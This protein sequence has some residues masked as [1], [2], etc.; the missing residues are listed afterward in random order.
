MQHLDDGTLQ[1]LLD[2][3]RSGLS[4]AERAAAEEHL[5]SCELCAR[6]LSELDAL[7]ER[8][9]TLLSEPASADVTVPPYENVVARADRD[10]STD[11][12]RRGR[13]EERVR[14]LAYRMRKR[15][16]AAA[17]AASVVL[18]VGIGWLANGQHRSSDAETE[19]AVADEVGADTLVVSSSVA[20]VEAGTD[21]TGRSDTLATF[22]RG[23]VTDDS[24][25]PLAGAQVSV[26]GTGV[27]ALTNRD[28]AFE[29]SVKPNADDSITRDVTL[30]AQMIGYAEASQTL[31]ARG[32]RVVSTDFR[33]T[34]Q[35]VALEGMVVSAVGDTT[36]SQGRSLG[37]RMDAPVVDSS[38]FPWR[39]VSAAVAQD[40]A[41]FRP[42]T[43]PG[44]R[45]LRI[46]VG[47]DEATPLVRILQELDDGGRLELVEAS[48]SQS[49]DRY[50]ASD[51]RSR[52]SVR[53]GDVWVAATAPLS[54]DSLTALLGRL[55]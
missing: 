5:A 54:R 11:R 16:R 49:P 14:G 3:P 53:R 24:G 45:V 4:D 42:L 51:A 41:G 48:G 33:L 17:W 22:V 1:G 19:R 43:V 29:L 20:V 37:S 9:E 6:R 8:T 55:K 47:R 50:L 26:Q 34:P 38:R 2:G 23:R 18:A 12:Q 28:G 13:P 35:P 15:W 10:D 46:E 27:G 30:K 39:S 25:K 44:L 7:S 40:E 36:R 32:G 52:A 21:S 31:A